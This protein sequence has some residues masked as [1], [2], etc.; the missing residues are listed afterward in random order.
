MKT[1][2]STESLATL[3]L[4]ELQEAEW[5]ARERALNCS[6][7]GREKEGWAHTDEANRLQELRHRVMEAQG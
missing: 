4:T 5:A 1:T 2:T 6:L 3:D 7:E